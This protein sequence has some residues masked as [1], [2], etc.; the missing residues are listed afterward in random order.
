[1]DKNLYDLTNSQKSIWLTE[2]FFQN[3]NINNI[4][5]TAIIN[6][7]IDFDLLAKSI[8]IL[9]EKNESFRL[10]FIKENQNLKQYIEPYK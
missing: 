8:N 4:C 3:T 6:Q 5:G 2:Q 7:E 9:V 1:M 10:K